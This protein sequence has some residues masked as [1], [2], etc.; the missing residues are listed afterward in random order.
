[1]LTSVLFRLL[2][3]AVLI[4]LGIYVVKRKFLNNIREKIKQKDA[5]EIDLILKRK[6]L[7][8]QQENIETTIA[9]ETVLIDKLKNNIME[10]KTSADEREQQRKAL[11][12]QSIQKLK[13]KIELQNE[14]R[15]LE[16]MRK[17]IIPEVIKESQEALKEKFTQPAQRRYVQEIINHIYQ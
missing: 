13:E 2:N 5:Q 10:W 4:A 9:Q 6:E 1:M 8:H 11:E 15:A 3:F 12:L 7:L 17:K 16:T 14:H